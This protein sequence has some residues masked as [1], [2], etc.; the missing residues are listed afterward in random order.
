[1]E[2]IENPEHVQTETLAVPPAN[3]FELDNLQ[4]D[5]AK[6]ASWFFW[7]A[8]LSVINSLL[9]YMGA[10][11]NFILG[12]GMTQLVDGLAAGLSNGAN[13]IALIPDLMIAGFFFYIGY[14]S[15][16][17]DKWAFV[18]GIILYTLDA[19]IYLFFSE[20]FAFGFHVFA[21]VMIIRG[22]IKVFEYN[23]INKLTV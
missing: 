2:N 18:T 7:I 14:R 5:I 12:L 8:G 1:M 16:K 4:V 21:L 10:N 9:F 17:I 3:K 11:M 15:K 22:F 19:L 6:A 20:W 13:F 23:K